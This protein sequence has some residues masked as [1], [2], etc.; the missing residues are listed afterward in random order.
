MNEIKDS[1]RIK[2]ERQITLNGGL[3]ES[4]GEEQSMKPKHMTLKQKR[5]AACVITL[6]YIG[7]LVLL[8]FYVGEPFIKML[9]NPG[10]FKDWVAAHGIWGPAIFVLMTAL[11]V[12]AAIIPGEPFEIA[13]GYAFG[14]VWGSILTLV[15]IVLGQAIVFFIVR[16]YG[17]RALD[18]FIPRS[19][20]DSVKFLGDSGNVTR[21][22]FI[23]FFIPGTPKDIMTYV[24]GLLKIDFSS[25]IVIT[26]IARLPSVISS[27]VGGSALSEGNYT[28]ALIVLGI[29]AAVSVLG[30]LLY[31]KIKKS[32]E[33]NHKI[34]SENRGTAK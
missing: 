2:K 26:M 31:S 34:N 8:F 9:D 15:G 27:T 19:K 30:M 32:I 18:L 16:R 14:W 22:L 33:K 29:T 11:Q 4:D 7:L 21:M 23:L 1:R 3:W 20:I 25:F 28:F 5:I 12:F 10:Q 13:A 6:A 24:S 17:R